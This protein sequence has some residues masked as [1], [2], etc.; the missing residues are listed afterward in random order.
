MARCH[1]A[2]IATFALLS[3]AGGT[4]LAQQSPRAAREFVALPY[5][6]ASSAFGAERPASPRPARAA[7]TAGNAEASRAAFERGVH[8]ADELAW[9]QAAEAFEESYRLYPR[10]G[11]LY[12]L[13]LTH[14]ALGQ[15]T[16]AIDELGRF[17]EQGNPSAEVREQVA[18][19]LEEMRHNLARLTIT[20]SVPSA[21]VTLDEQ[22]V[23][24]GTAIA[25]DPGNHIVSVSAP[26]YTRNA[27][28]VTLTR[29]ETRQLDV[30]LERAGGGVLS[31]WWFWTA[32]GVVVAGGVAA[33]V[34]LLSHEEPPNCGTLNVCIMPQ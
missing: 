27:Q 14:R 32:V 6:V 1:T 22:P 7:Q 15:Y 34:V 20:P 33:S 13:G 26:G 9:Q 31:Q 2:A 16:R 30:R 10:P 5:S 24:A 8:L 19:V 3:L 25:T 17:L 11:T 21:T 28:M 29:G 23:S 4:A 18:Q 12:N